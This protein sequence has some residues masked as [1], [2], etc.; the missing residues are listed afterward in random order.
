MIVFNALLAVLIFG[1]TLFLMTQYGGVYFRLSLAVIF[2]VL[3]AISLG[4]DFFDT[5][6]VFLYS[7]PWAV[8]AW[9]FAYTISMPYQIKKAGNVV[10]TYR[11]NPSDVFWR[12]I[13]VLASSYLAYTLLVPNQYIQNNLNGYFRFELP[14]GVAAVFLTVI[15]IFNL[16]RKGK[17]RE[18]GIVAPDLGCFFSWAGYKSYEWVEYR[19]K[20]T[21]QFLL[22]LNGSQNDSVSI[23]YLSEQDKN[24]LE[25]LL[26]KK[27]PQVNES[28]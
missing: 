5:S 24:I 7:F 18:N 20:D 23:D 1:A 13:N 27:L 26:S 28:S 21:K 2:I 9:L 25:E 8:F 11:S 19:K 16:L 17:F 6:A 15:S 4:E 14:M 3:I 10:L 22:Y 12:L